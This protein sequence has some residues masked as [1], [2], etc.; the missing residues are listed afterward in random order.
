MTDERYREIDEQIES[1]GWA[2]NRQSELFETV[3][4]ANADPSPVDWQ[5]LLVALPDLSLNELMDY[6]DR[7]RRV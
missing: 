7:K 6:E 3:R 4:R 2:Y 1:L 5:N